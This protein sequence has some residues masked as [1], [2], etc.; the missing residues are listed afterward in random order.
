MSGPLVRP[1]EAIDD[2]LEA[3]VGELV[4]LGGGAILDGMRHDHQRRLESQRGV[5]R[6]SGLDEFGRDHVDARDAP[7]VEIDEVVQ[8]A[9]RA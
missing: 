3:L 6:V 4:Q 1:C 9:R 2:L 5:L 7:A 8:T